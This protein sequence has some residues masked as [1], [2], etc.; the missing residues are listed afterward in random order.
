M[1]SKKDLRELINQKLKDADILISNRRYSTAFYIAG[2]ALELA[3]K[4]KICKIFKF[5]QRFPEGKFDFS[6]YQNSFKHQ[7]LLANTIT[8]IRDIK[9]HDLNNLLFYSGTEY[10]IKLN[11]LNEWNLVVNWNPEMRYKTQKLL[12]KDVVNKFKA[13]KT[14][15]QNIL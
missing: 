2:Y 9:S 12:K 6:L 1:I 3:L 5:T 14:L 13:I 4:L 7:K 8:K 15:I 11:Y 10:D